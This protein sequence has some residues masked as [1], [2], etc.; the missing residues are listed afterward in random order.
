[1]KARSY[2]NSQK[3]KAITTASNSE[4]NAFKRKYLKTIANTPCL[5]KRTLSAHCK[6]ILWL[7]FLSTFRVP[8][9]ASHWKESSSDR[10]SEKSSTQASSLCNT[11]NSRDEG[12]CCWPLNR[13]YGTNLKP[14]S[15]PMGDSMAVPNRTEKLLEGSVAWDCLW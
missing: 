8:C 1:M 15:S 11:R 13:Q 4:V 3:L 10:K 5:P 12:K 9:T 2:R 6:V 14:E 7:R